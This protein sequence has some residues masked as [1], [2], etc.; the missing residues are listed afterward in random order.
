MTKFSF[1]FSQNRHYGQHMEHPQ[2]LSGNCNPNIMTKFSHYNT[3]NNSDVSSC[4]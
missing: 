2:D 1:H 3:T 4:I